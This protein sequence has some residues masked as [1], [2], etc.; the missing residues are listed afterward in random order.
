VKVAVPWN[1][2]NYIPSNGFHPLYRALFEHAA[3]E[4]ELNAWD[5]VKLQQR[6]EGDA[7]LRLAILHRALVRKHQA[8]PAKTI[9][10]AYDEHFGPENAVLTEAL[11]GDLEFHHTAPFPSLA[12]PFVFHC[13]SFAPVFMPFAQQGSGPFDRLEDLKAHYR[14]IFSSPLCLGIHSHIPETLESFRLFFGDAAIDGKLRPSRIGLS[15]AGLPQGSRPAKRG[16]DKPRFLFFNSANQNPDNFFLRGGHIVLRFWKEFVSAGRAGQLILRCERPDEAAL[17][18]HGVDIAFVRAEAGR[19]IVWITE[20][21]PHEEISALMADAHFFL[22]PS[23]SLH[24]VSILFALAL[25][26]VPVVTDTIGTSVYVADRSTGIVLTGV[27]DEVWRRDPKSDILVDTFASTPS[28]DAAL[29]SQLV[30]RIFEMLDAPE[31]YARCSKAAQGVSDRE[32]AGE[33][34]SAQFWSAVTESYERGRS[35]K[36]GIPETSSITQALGDCTLAPA[37][38]ARVFG[39]AP[40]PTRRLNTGLSSVWELGGAMILAHGNPQMELRHW[41]PLVQYLDPEAPKVRFASALADFNGMYLSPDGSAGRTA[42]SPLRERVSKAL[43]PYPALHSTA[44][45]AYRNVARLV[46]V[47]RRW[48]GYLR[49]QI[50]RSDADPHVELLVEGVEGYNVFRF[51]HKYHAIP[52]HEGRFDPAKAAARKYASVYSG[53]TLNGV[54]RKIT[55]SRVD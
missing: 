40:Q 15:S 33:D 7:D 22:L 12:R 30:A 19:S 13:E 41:S 21:Q 6:F 14:R 44:G 54:V 47:S 35:P 53:Y 39:S 32:F 20:F 38:W 28:L 17:A 26:T 2:S 1:L 24:S 34:F 37:D 10:H 49:H 9:A 46:R 52:Q 4:I 16:L 43:M 8:R 27:R 23:K 50:A 18:E 48:R 51:F 25:G 5:N 42:K 3:A 31:A 55:A 45:F 36:A 11:A 29:V